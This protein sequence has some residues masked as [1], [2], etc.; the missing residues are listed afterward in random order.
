MCLKRPPAGCW[1]P[2]S[3][4]ARH[5]PAL[6]DTFQRFYGPE[7]HPTSPEEASRLATCAWV[8]CLWWLGAARIS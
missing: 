5:F 3:G 1:R 2:L 8:V 6:F 7:K 4:A